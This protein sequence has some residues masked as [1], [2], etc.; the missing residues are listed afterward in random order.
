MAESYARHMNGN[1]HIIIVGRNKSAAD[2]IV[3]SFPKPNDAN[4]IHEFIP[5]DVSLVSNVH[6]TTALLLQRLQRIDYLV[7]SSG[8]LILAGRNETSEGL[9]DKMALSYYSRWTFIH[10]LLPLMRQSPQGAKVYTVLA[11]G[12]NASI[13]KDD[14]DLKKGHTLGK[15]TAALT[16]YTNVAF[17]VW[18]SN[19]S[20]LLSRDCAYILFGCFRNSQKMNPKC[21]SI[22]LSLDLF[23]RQ[24]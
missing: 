13:E 9:D 2:N 10:D 24:C 21:H 17:Q 5:C 6:K 4:V 14:L 19:T 15:M 22:M 7:L 23:V 12:A 8:V 3:A 1:A 20:F 18:S 16:T 11:S